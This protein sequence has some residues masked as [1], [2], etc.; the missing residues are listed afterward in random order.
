VRNARMVLFDT[1]GVQAPMTAH[2]LRQM[3][4]EVA[5]LPP[6]DG[7]FTD[8]GHDAPLIAP[9]DHRYRRPYEGTDNPA[10]AMQAYLDW[11]FGLIAQLERDGTHFFRVL[12]A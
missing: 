12:E 4:W 2:W 9:R 10:A 5:V 6:D 8:T 3:G 7:A 1:L 11:E